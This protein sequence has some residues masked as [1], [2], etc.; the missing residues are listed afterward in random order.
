VAQQDGQV[1]EA[2]DS[3]LK[4]LCSDVQN[5]PALALTLA[6]LEKMRGLEERLSFSDR[7]GNL[8]RS[9]NTLSVRI[10]QLFCPPN[11]SSAELAA[12]ADA[13]RELDAIG[14]TSQSLLAEALGAAIAEYL[15]IWPAEQAAH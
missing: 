12:I 13:K 6:T 11:N 9:P 1:I 10:R 7:I 2:I 14:G 3:M 15:E 5:D 8:C 4:V